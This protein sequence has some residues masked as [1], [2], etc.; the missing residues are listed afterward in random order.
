MCS[1]YL[2]F[3]FAVSFKNIFSKTPLY[4]LLLQGHLV[5]FIV[6]VAAFQWSVKYFIYFSTLYEGLRI[7]EALNFCI[8]IAD[9]VGKIDW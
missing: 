5:Y 2:I 6:E 1:I 9:L 4:A 8:S 3:S 7:P